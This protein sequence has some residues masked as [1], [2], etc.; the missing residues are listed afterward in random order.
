[1]IRI[2]FVNWI[3]W[4]NVFRKQQTKINVLINALAVFIYR[5]GLKLSVVWTSNSGIQVG[6]IELLLQYFRHHEIS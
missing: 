3:N 5:F 4:K 1:M 6:N 2:T